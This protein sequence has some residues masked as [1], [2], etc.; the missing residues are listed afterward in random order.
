MWCVLRTSTSPPSFPLRVRCRRPPRPSSPLRYRVSVRHSWDLFWKLTVELAAS[1]ASNQ[2]EQE[3]QEGP[4]F[5]LSSTA[6]TLS[7]TAERAFAISGTI[8]ASTGFDVQD[9]NL[10]RLTLPHLPPNT[11]Q[12]VSRPLLPRSYN[13]H[14][15]RHWT[16]HGLDF[17]PEVDL[18]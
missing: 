10:S 17:P 3:Q 18:T 6:G 16:S 11:S 1:L 4:H 12:R 2:I 7:L 8:T 13:T 5:F 9:K 14:L 15:D